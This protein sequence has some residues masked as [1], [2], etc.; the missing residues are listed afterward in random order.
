MKVI[1]ESITERDA[2]D[3]YASTRVL[4]NGEPIGEGSYG[5]EPEDNMRGRDYSWVEP[6]LLKLA[7]TLGADAECV[8]IEREAQP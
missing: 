7:K 6:L 2:W 8:T 3:S 4:V 5:G 1:I